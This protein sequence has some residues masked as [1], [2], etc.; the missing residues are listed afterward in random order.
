ME[1]SELEI[2]GVWLGKPQTFYDNRGSFREWFLREEFKLKSG[3][4][5]EIAQN[6]EK[7]LIDIG[8]QLCKI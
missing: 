7:Q 1:Y 3:I 8:K 2:P 6:F 4:D 5:F